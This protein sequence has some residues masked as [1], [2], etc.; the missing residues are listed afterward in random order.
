MTTA[1]L[2]SWSR[3]LFLFTHGLF[4]LPSYLIVLYLLGA[5]EK[6]ARILPENPSLMRHFLTF[7]SAPG[8]AGT[9]PPRRRNRRCRLAVLWVEGPKSVEQVGGRVSS[10][11]WLVC[12]VQDG[13][14]GKTQGLARL[15]MVRPRNGLSKALPRAG[16][17]QVDVI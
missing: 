17:R 11:S 8:A 4:P 13:N 14:S 6:T 16:E 7:S 12:F 15:P 1:L 9:S 3:R 5:G 2:L 10:P